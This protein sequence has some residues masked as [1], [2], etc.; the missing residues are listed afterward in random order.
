[1]A[2]PRITTDPDQ[3]EG[4]KPSRQFVTALAR[5]LEVMDAFVPEGRPLG[6]QEIAA[7][8]G[9]PKPT[10]SRIAYTLRELGYLV[11]EPHSE[12]YR[13]GARVL[14]FGQAFGAGM[15]VADIA[16]EPMQALADA[17][18]VTVALGQADGT[19]MVYLVLRRSVSRVMLRQDVG[20]RIPIATTAMGMAYLHTLPERLRAAAIARVEAK[21]GDER[22]AFR[23]RLVRT[24]IEMRE[25][26]YCVV[27]GS[28]D[29]GINGAATA[30]RRDDGESVL[31][32][33][34]GG[35]SFWLSEEDLYGQAGARL[36]E[37]RKALLAAGITRLAPI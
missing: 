22:D 2:R 20:S 13:L 23:E 33:N 16:A 11:Y 34:I 9:L 4:A 26:G 12:K 25:R 35:P 14:G 29:R 7:R 36:M 21:L 32:L 8:T 31:A 10:V 6:N 24:G 28:W 17:A 30:L 18:R 15:R 3:A 5:G 27:A 19:E 1:M 37:T